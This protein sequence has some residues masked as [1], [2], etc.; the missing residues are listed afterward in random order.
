MHPSDYLSPHLAEAFLHLYQ[1][2]LPLNTFQLSPTRKEFSGD[3]TLLIFPLIKYTGKGPEPAGLEIGEWLLAN[4]DNITG[5]NVIKGFLN[6]TLKPEFW[7]RVTQHYAWQDLVA[8]LP[9]NERVLVEYSSPNTNKPLHLGHIRNILLGWSTAR[10]MEKVGYEVV[11]VQVIND[12]GIAICKSMLAWKKFGNGSTPE[13]TGIKGD[14]FVGNY[15]VAFESAFREEYHS[16]QTS[17]EAQAMYKNHVGLKGSDHQDEDAFFK[18]YK[19]D[20]FNTYSS[21]GKEAREMLLLWEKGDSEVRSVWNQMNSWVYSGFDTTY[22]RLGVHFDRVYWESETYILGNDLVDKGLEDDVF[23][24]KEDG[25]V[26]VDLTAQGL[27]H[28][29]LRRSD[30]TSLYITQDLGT[31]EERYRD[32]HTRRMVYVVADEQ[33]Y[34]FQVLFA[35]MQLLKAPYAEGMFHLSYGM[36]ELPTGRMKSREGTVVD[37]D[38]LMDEVILE[39]ENAAVERGESAHIPIPEQTEIYRKVGLAAMK[40]HIIKVNPRKRMVFDPVESVDMQGHTGPY[41]QN[42]YVRIQS[43]LQKAGHPDPDFSGNAY[44]FAEGERDLLVLMG[45][46][47]ATILQAAEQYDPSHVANYAYTL[48]KAFHKFYHEFQILRAESE[49]AKQSRLAIATAT[50]RVLKDA[51]DLLGIEMP[52]RM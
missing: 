20:Y 19:N 41:I 43:I 48:A 27:D 31:A 13:T 6:L 12:R 25:S 11:K 17:E 50:G 40:F 2:D 45:E 46:Y 8:F 10:I 39:A 1:Q 37:A 15:Y 22:D 4:T 9:K 16:W 14:H 42:A 47:K 29:I 18:A 7:H 28:K 51:M 35:V 5:Y 30:G 34:H 32:F 23:Y 21:L 24:R 33:N 3:Y 38:D 52:D 26:W 49:D 44:V 36:V